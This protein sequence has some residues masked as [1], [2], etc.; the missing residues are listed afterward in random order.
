[1]SAVRIQISDDLGNISYLSRT[2][3]GYWNL[4]SRNGIALGLSTV[5]NNEPLARFALEDAGDDGEAL[6]EAIKK[7]LSGKRTATLLFPGSD[8]PRKGAL[9]DEEKRDFAWILTE[10]IDLSVDRR[11]GLARNEARSEFESIKRALDYLEA[12]GADMSVQRQALGTPR[13]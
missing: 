12:N 4:V 7:H 10:T 9:S 8:T 2:T 11:D 6:L 1:M 5:V 3:G 13:F